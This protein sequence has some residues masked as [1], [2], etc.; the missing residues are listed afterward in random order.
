MKPDITELFIN[1][2]RNLFDALKIINEKEIHIVLVVDNENRLI[3]TITDGDIR[4]G[5]LR[6]LTLDSSVDEVT[7][8][9]FYSINLGDDPNS[10][11][12]IMSKYDINQIPVLNNEGIVVDI[13]EKFKVYEQDKLPNHVVIMAGGLGKRLLPHTSDCPKPML[14]IG[15]KPILEIILLECISYGLDKFYIS[16]NYL[17]E[18]IINYFGN[19]EKW[20]VEINYIHEP[21]RMGTAGSLRFLP[22]SLDSPFLVLNGDVLTRLN[23]R[24]LLKFHDEQSSKATICVKKHEMHIPFGVVKNKG[25]ELDEISEKPS[26]KFLINAGVYV[27]N[28]ELLKL[29]PENEFTDMPPFLQYCKDL[30]KTINLCPI[31]EYWIDIGRPETLEEAFQTWQNE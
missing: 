19:G 1:Q 5:L 17:K 26:F 22:N 29:L 4:R 6:G 28:P 30:G 9:N 20:G 3:G 16:V 10:A 23:Y 13:I 2:E 24:N 7:N 8:K 21:K 27:L 12:S 31:H 14:M 11:K 25:I 18:K 15:D